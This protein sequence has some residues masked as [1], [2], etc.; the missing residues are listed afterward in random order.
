[1]LKS[2][3]VPSELRHHAGGDCDELILDSAVEQRRRED[4]KVEN[5]GMAGISPK[6]EKLHLAGEPKSPLNLPFPDAFFASLRLS[7]SNPIAEFRF[8]SNPGGSG[9]EFPLHRPAGVFFQCAPAA[10]A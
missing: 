5:K 8:I 6:P 7:C 9:P 1:M 4:A 3:P 2:D 10:A